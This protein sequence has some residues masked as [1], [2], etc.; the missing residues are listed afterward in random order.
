M[1]TLG[2][3]REFTDRLL[4]RLTAEPQ[5][6]PMRGDYAA[7][8]TDLAA[9]TW[10]LFPIA[11][12]MTDGT[13]LQLRGERGELLAFDSVAERDQAVVSNAMFFPDPADV[14]RL[15]W[16]PFNGLAQLRVRLAKLRGDDR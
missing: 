8:C 4:A 11:L 13:I 1:T 14:E 6:R 7:V 10:E 3:R 5:Q 2:A 16:L 9:D 15:C 12:V